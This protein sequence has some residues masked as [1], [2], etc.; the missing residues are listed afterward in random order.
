MFTTIARSF[1]SLS[2]LRFRHC[3]ATSCRRVFGDDGDNPRLARC[4]EEADAIAL[5]RP[6]CSFFIAINEAACQCADVIQAA[7]LKKIL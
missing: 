5:Q 7:D 4:V 1:L 2:L 3:L 6:K